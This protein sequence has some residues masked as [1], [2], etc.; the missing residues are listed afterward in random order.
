MYRHFHTTK[1]VPRST[2]RSFSFTWFQ[3]FRF[4]FF[5]HWV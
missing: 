2:S 3:E 1:F 4:F 5:S